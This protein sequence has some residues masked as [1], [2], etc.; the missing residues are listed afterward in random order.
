MDDME[1]QAAQDAAQQGPAIEQVDDQALVPSQED[2]AFQE[3]FA[4]VR[5]DPSAEP[6]PPKLFAGYTEEQLRDFVGKA[7]EIDEMRKREAKVFGTLGSLKQ[8]MDALRNQH[9]QQP[10]ATAL[11]L[12]ASKFTRLQEQFPELAD[13]LSQDLSDA[14]KG[15]GGGGSADSQAME[16]MVDERLDRTSKG[17]ET[18]LLSV[19]HPDWRK[20]AQAPEFQAWTAQQAPDVQQVVR[21]GWDA[22]AV[23]EALSAYKQ[24]N[25]KAVQA[26]QSR[27]SRLESGMTPRGNTQMAPAMS[28][29]DAFEQGFR[30]VR[31]KK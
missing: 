19:M 28:E 18:K 4:E 14:L 13:M 30:S 15:H 6:E 24:W 20:V 22:I 9:R 10:Q 7:Q 26:K 31:G 29:A 11:H 12:D 1:P 27:Q 25:N 5:A 23:G 8:G 21:D 2:A 17:Y 3:G 16:R